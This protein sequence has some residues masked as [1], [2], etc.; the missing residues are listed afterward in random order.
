MTW[1]KWL[2]Y[3]PGIVALI[4]AIVTITKLPYETKA[5]EGDAANKFAQ[6]A[7]QI[8]GQNLTLQQRVENLEDRVTEVEQ[9]NGVLKKEVSELR[10]ENNSLRDWAERLCAQVISLNGT[11]V[12]YVGPP[13]V[14]R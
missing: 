13:K 11:P 6:A 2:P 14:K 7:G 12:N 3:L 9:E 8:A 5:L 4:L 1:K 10:D